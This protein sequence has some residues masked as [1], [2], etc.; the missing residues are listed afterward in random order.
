MEVELLEDIGSL[1]KGDIA[2]FSLPV[3]C[4]LIKDKMAKV[5]EPKKP[6]TKA[7]SNKNKVTEIRKE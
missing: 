4:G 6:K 5:P 3:V 1:K 2:Y 7:T